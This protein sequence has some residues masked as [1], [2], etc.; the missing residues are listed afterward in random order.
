LF[1]LPLVRGITRSVGQLTA[2]TEQIAQ[3]HFETRVNAGRRDELGKLGAS[4]NR[5][6]T[7]LDTHMTGQKR[8]LGDVAHELCSPLARLQMATG[9][10]ADQAPK[11]LQETVA[12]VRE[13]VQQMSA[14]VNELLAFTKAGLRPRDVVSSPVDLAPLARDVLAREDVGGRVTLSVADD[15]RANAEPDLLARAL[16]NLVRNALRYAGE[17]GPITVTAARENK[18]VSLVVEDN[19]PGVPAADLDRLGEPFFRPELA[20]TR[21]SGGVGLGLAIVRNSIA[22][23]G[24]EVRFSNRTPQGFRAEIRLATA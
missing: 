8:F 14:L 3:G 24:G 5:M 17:A 4:V 2:A 21:E 11:D 18:Q 1:W 10:L 12:D 7:R 9:I 15:V 23:C 13:E 22:A 16:G 20:R 19:G 6:A